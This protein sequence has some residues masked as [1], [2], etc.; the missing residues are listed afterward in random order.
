MRHMYF[1]LSI[2]GMLAL[3][4]CG[5]QS[6]GETAVPDSVEATSTPPPSTTSTEAYPAMPTMTATTPAENYPAPE[7]P[8]ATV[9]PTAYPA[10][11]EVWILRPFGQQCEDPETFAY[12]DLNA[13]VEA[14]EQAGVEVLASEMVTIPV[15]QSCDCPTSEHFRVQIRAE[16]LE[17]TQSMGW[18]QE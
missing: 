3:A 11:K 5:P 6:G 4:A 10:E 7:T 18:V 16:A 8:E 9:E 12:E 1:M 13:A 17:T 2:I 15:C 14:L